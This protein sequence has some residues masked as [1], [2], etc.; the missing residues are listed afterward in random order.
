MKTN[1][2][3]TLMLSV[4]LLMGTVANGQPTEKKAAPFKEI[5]QNKTGDHFTARE[6]KKKALQITPSSVT[7]IYSHAVSAPIF[8]PRDNRNRGNH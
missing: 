6:I 4:I 3:R 7:I 8:R 5:Y 2:A 1:P